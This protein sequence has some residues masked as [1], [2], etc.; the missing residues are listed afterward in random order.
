MTN[1]PGA[2]AAAGL[3]GYRFS[4]SRPVALCLPDTL[5]SAADGK[6]YAIDPDF[7]TVLACLRK[8]TNPDGEQ[9]AK[10]L[11]LAH[12]FYKGQP[13]PDAD[14]LFAAFVEGSVYAGETED[15]VAVRKTAYSKP[16]GMEKA[17]G[18][19]EAKKTPDMSK[20]A[21]SKPADAEE[22]IGMPDTA[23]EYATAEAAGDSGTP[24]MDFEQDAGALYASFL[25]QYG[26][27]LLTQKLHWFAFREL[28]AG[29][30]EDTAFGA[31]VRLRAMEGTHLPPEERAQLRRL[32][33]KVAI[34][35][36][37]G[38]AEKALLAELDARLAAGENPDDVL[39]R[40]AQL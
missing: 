5:Q 19:Q 16:A 11:Y 4:L 3:R 25:Q 31:R 10:W 6:V 2:L 37:I 39:R 12:R 22:T 35:P 17:A 1:P 36:R 32:K 28:V 27:D 24:L 30:G 34:V 13:P 40:L 38:K 18:E 20:A 14:R 7:H 26:I 9:P 23:E 8:L 29:L 33:E 21:Y 15:T